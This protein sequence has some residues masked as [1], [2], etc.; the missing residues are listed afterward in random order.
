MRVSGFP[1]I[2]LLL[3]VILV[4]WASSSLAQDQDHLSFIQ[5]L[6]L[7]SSPLFPISTNLYNPEDASYS[8][9]L[10]ASIRNLR[11]N[12]SYTPKPRLIIT[13]THE[14]HVQAAILCGKSHGLEMR[15]RSGGHDYE[16]S[17]YVSFVP[18]FV[19]DL[20]NFRSIDVNIKEESA[21]VQSGATVGE[22]Y[23][24]IANKSKVH[25]FPAGMCP[26]IGVGGHFSGGGFGNMMRKYGLSVDN[27]IDA[28]LVDAQGRILERESMGEDL[29]WAITG[30]GAASFGVVLA[31]KIKL[32]PVPQNVTVFQVEKTG[33][34]NITESVHR[35]L[36]IAD[37]FDRDVFFTM[38][39]DVA[40]RGV[41]NKNK[42][43]RA[44]FMGFFLGDSERLITLMN[45]TFPELGL[46][47]QDCHQVSWI[48]SVVYWGNFSIN[49]GTST[50]VLLNRTPPELYHSKMKSDYLQRSIPK[51]GLKLIFKKM[52][53]LEAPYMFFYPYGGKMS[54]ISPD[55]K[56]FPHRAGNIA[57]IMYGTDWTEHGFE[58]EYYYS[59][60]TRKLYDF[61]TPFVSKFPRQAYL[62]F[63]DFDLGINHHGQNSYL[64]GKGYGDKYFKENYDR[65]VEIKSRVDPENYFKNEQSIPLR[66]LPEEGKLH[67]GI[68]VI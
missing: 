5:C 26:T 44:T 3:L 57:N 13:A 30:G 54:E 68:S 41:E 14:S 64:Q 32:V 29:F 61:M 46:L 12:E 22:L 63:K 31:Y 36:E 8:S 55:A 49:N 1:S 15:I 52:V 42:T 39:L 35:W 67:K 45:E 62:N 56:P 37:G 28:K 6:K 43:I 16:G 18:F 20:F 60:L 11:F 2:H 34:D 7:Y 33:E 38:I 17:S 65:L 59:G 66:P 58:A 10:S 51:E 24:A 40:N 21:W 53:E 23:Y 19:L 50:E 25:G 47:N 48:E 4:S 27:I 9:V